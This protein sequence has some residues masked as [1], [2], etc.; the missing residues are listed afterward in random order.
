MSFFVCNMLSSRFQYVSNA[1][2]ATDLW[3]P[4]ESQV[5]LNVEQSMG[6]ESKQILFLD[7]LWTFPWLLFRVPVYAQ[8]GHS[9]WH[10]RMSFIIIVKYFSFFDVWKRLPW[11]SVWQR[12]NELI[13]RSFF[14]HSNITFKSVSLYNIHSKE[15]LYNDDRHELS[16]HIRVDRNEVVQKRS[17]IE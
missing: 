1:D 9:S 15:I 6:P 2:R 10:F 7:V 5:N 11:L 8:L 13:F 4:F 16:C 3:N 12:E 17:K 14:R